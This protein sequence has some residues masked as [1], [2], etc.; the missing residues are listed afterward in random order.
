MEIACFSA[1]LKLDLNCTWT[2]SIFLVNPEPKPIDKNT[3]I[4]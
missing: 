4:Y 3:A 1:V 2:G